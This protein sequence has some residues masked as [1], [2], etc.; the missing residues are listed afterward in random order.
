MIVDEPFVDRMSTLHKYVVKGEFGAVQLAVLLTDVRPPMAVDLGYHS[1]VPLY[2]EQTPSF[3]DCP[4]TGGECYYDGSG[5]RAMEVYKEFRTR[6]EEWLWNELEEFY[7]ERL[8]PKRTGIRKF[9]LEED[10]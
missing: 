1:K 10:A 2:D 9:K 6:G 7:E 3:T 8:V 4:F 5:L